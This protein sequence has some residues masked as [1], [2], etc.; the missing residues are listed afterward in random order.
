MHGMMHG[1][2]MG[3]GS[4]FYGMGLFWILVALIT[5]IAVVWLMRSDKK[6]SMAVHQNDVMKQLDER[7]VQGEISEE[8]YDHKKRKIQDK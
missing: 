2:G 7:F 8:E 3:I 6:S 4:G 5:I 1:Y